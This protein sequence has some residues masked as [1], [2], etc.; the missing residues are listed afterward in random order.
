MTISR[1][2]ARSLFAELTQSAMV[3]L[4]PDELLHMPGLRQHG[5][6]FFG[7]L[8][9]R[10]YKHKARWTYDERDIRAAGREMASL[11]LRLEDVV[12]VHLPPYSEVADSSPEEW[13]RPSWRRQMVS[14]MFNRARHE[15]ILE[16][17]S[18]DEWGDWQRIGSNGLPGELTLE[19][20]LASSSRYRHMQN[21]AGTRPLQLLT[22]SGEHWLLPGVYV[23]L[24]DRWEEREDELVAR[25]S[26]CSSCGDRS[27][28][29]SDWRTPTTS[30]YVTRCPPCSG[31][32]F[33][34]YTGHLG[35]V[36]YE[37]VRRRG[38]RA[39]DY[40]CRLCKAS[41]ASAWDH[42]HEHGHV[43]GPLCG[44][45]NTR[46]GKATPYSFL[47]LEGGLLHLLEC[48][49][50]LTQRTLPRRFHLDVVRAH[51]QRT[52]RHGQRC[53]RQPYVQALEQAHG[54]HR[55]RLQCSGWH[56]TGDWTKDVTAA[57]VT[58]MVRSLVDDA[59]AEKATASSSRPD[60]G[61]EL[62][63]VLCP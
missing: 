41:Q 7:D 60:S 26:L 53:R 50:C 27:P 14:W 48:R 13:G 15:L 52:E 6:V 22:W 45:C 34:L 58:A 42:C 16:G 37:T 32:A 54:V 56:T 43:R 17:R 1:E 3:P 59:V 57:E 20:F 31:S 10:C 9:V 39:D 38:T 44:S 29:W 33:Q 18:Y 47:Q 2:Y 24:L 62:L 23:D 35:G 51:L 4:D 5:H 8:A 49:S 30:G 12:E 25:A 11:E 40:L 21:I 61:R 19:G 36:Q 63:H 28:N 55:F 46:E